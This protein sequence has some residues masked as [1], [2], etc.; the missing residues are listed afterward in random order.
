MVEIV[1]RPPLVILL[2]AGGLVLVA[3]VSMF[4]K[5]GEPWR[6]ITALVIVVVAA[7]LFVVLVYRRTTLT[8]DETGLRTDGMNPIDL[9]WEDV[10]HAYFETNL[11]F[12]EY[13]PTV[14]T[15]GIAIG[16]YRTGRF[17]LS[18]GDS[19]RVLLEQSDQAIVLITGDLTYLFGP[20]DID[21]LAH[22]VNEF[23]VI[24]DT[25]Q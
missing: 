2:F 5:R 14:R 23:R 25:A 12:S 3:V 11:P 16:T 8:V 20:A 22:A 6:K 4:V 19:A 24:P 15:R 9:S 18:N 21:R 7:V 10:Q 1:F 17:L 13:R